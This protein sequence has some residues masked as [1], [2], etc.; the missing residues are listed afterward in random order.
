MKI[1]KLCVFCEHFEMD[2]GCA[3]TQGCGGEDF[4]S[5]KKGVVYFRIS[6]G[7]EDDFRKAIL[8]AQTC[9]HYQQVDL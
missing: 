2:A 8:T 7:E 9:E 3:D 4:M 5:C 6:S 1:E